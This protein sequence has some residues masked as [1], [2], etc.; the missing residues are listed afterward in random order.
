[1]EQK[2]FCTWLQL[3]N[4]QVSEA[5]ASWWTELYPIET[6]GDCE[7]KALKSAGDDTCVEF[8]QRLCERVKASDLEAVRHGSIRLDA[9]A[10]WLQRE[11]GQEALGIE[12]G[13]HLLEQL[14]FEFGVV[15]DFEPS[16]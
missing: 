9:F 10:R 7:E 16:V 3:G 4:L 1:M 15:E 6:S 8:F 14:G 2:T 11:L 5:L 12:H 13:T